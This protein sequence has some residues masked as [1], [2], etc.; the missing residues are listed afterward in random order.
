MPDDLI[1][2]LALKFYHGEYD[3][4]HIDSRKVKKGDAFL[5]LPGTKTHGNAFVEVA[6]KKG[7]KLVVVDQKV[8]H[9]KAR[10]VVAVANPEKFLWRLAKA[11]ISLS[12]A[13]KVAITGSNG[14]TTT[15]DLTAL[16]LGG[17]GKKV[18]K[19]R[20]NY[21]NHLGV[22]LTLCRLKH[23]HK[24]AVI[25]IGTSGVGEI[26]S[27]TNLTKPHMSVLT[28][29]NAAHMEGLKNLQAVALEKS[30]IFRGLKSGSLCFLRKKEMKYATVKS[31][32]KHLKPEFFDLNHVEAKLSFKKNKMTW[33]HNNIEFSLATPAIHNVENAEA[34]ICVAE[35]MG[36]STEVISRRLFKWMPS[37]HRMCILN[38][39]KRTLIDDCYNANPASMIAAVESALNLK[40]RNEQKVLLAMADM[41]E[42]GKRSGRVHGDLGKDLAK[43]GID[44]LLTMGQ[45][46]FK[47]LTS[48]EKNG[49]ESSM[50]CES[51]EEMGAMLQSLSRPHDIVLIKGSRGMHLEEVIHQLDP[52]LE[53]ALA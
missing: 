23:H 49:G 51:T 8:P 38:W 28:S 12:E 18:L 48:F 10:E 47:T 37:A 36:I 7:A 46:S 31:S 24:F 53:T 19:T 44:V 26:K 9:K 50:H 45:D 27:L 4:L 40:K 20:G 14:K 32:I 35:A 13:K 34:A 11:M 1:G 2:T 21:N 3:E 5:A 43:L 41:K 39:R 30:D 42:M 25:E 6:L 22:P 16:A 29:V 52:K 15:K 17:E 33:S